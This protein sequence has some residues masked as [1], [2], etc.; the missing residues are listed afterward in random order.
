M[1]ACYLIFVIELLIRLFV[2]QTRFHYSTWNCLDAFIIFLGGIELFLKLSGM[3]LSG[4]AVIRVVRLCRLLRL[5]RVM[6]LFTVLKELRRLLQM[7]GSCFKT[8]FWSCLLLV[9]IMTIW[10]VIAVEVL[11]PLVQEVAIKSNPWEGCERCRR[12]FASVFMANISFFQTV[13][14]GDSWGVM[15]V[16]VIEAY[17]WSAFI[18]IGALLTLVFGVLNLIVAVIVDTFAE[19]RDKDVVSR[20]ADMDAEEI[21][22]KKVLANIFTKID[23]DGGGTLSYEELQEGARRVAEFRH[24]LRV[25]DIDARDL[26]QLFL[27]VD[28]DESGEID[29]DEF[30][31]AMY[32]MKNTESKTATKFVKHLVTKLDLQQQD[33]KVDLEGNFGSLTTAVETSLSHAK[34]A[35][36][37]VAEQGAAMQKVVD[38]NEQHWHK[39]EEIIQQRL[40]V[41]EEVLQKSVDI[42]VK[43]ASEVALEAALQAAAASAKNV[44]ATVSLKSNTLAKGVHSR[45]AFQRQTSPSSSPSTLQESGSEVCINVGGKE[46]K[47]SRG[48]SDGANSSI[49]AVAND[50]ADMDS[51]LSHTKSSMAQFY[52]YSG[53]HGAS[54]SSQ[55]EDFHPIGFQEV[56][57]PPRRLS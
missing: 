46:E 44:M 13:V 54:S 1:D 32:R 11:N 38:D 42:A 6:R 24:W 35:M 45:V 20:A 23:A 9:L 31:E 50:V 48:V 56:P 40:R 34:K 7:M 5:I 57:Q 4:F 39:T 51:G 26:R 49:C 28:E 15:A 2:E 21:A 3:N 55:P 52:H 30:I 19:N 14:A 12:S 36:E 16:P 27:I 10:A 17:P 8:L 33:L 22:E 43:K 29:P 41:Q 53:P 18:F 37:T 47:M 25:M